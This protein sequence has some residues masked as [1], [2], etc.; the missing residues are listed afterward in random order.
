MKLGFEESQSAYSSGSQSARAWTE[1][2]VRSWAY[3]PN[4]GNTSL[5]SFPNNAPVADF[6]CG[7]C[8]EEFELKSKKGKFGP[9]LANGSFKTKC[10]RLAASN[11][12]NFFLIHR[13]C[14]ARQLSHST[15]GSRGMALFLNHYTCERCRRRWADEWSCMCDDSCP[16]C[17][18]RDIAPHT[19]EDLTTLIG[20]R[21]DAF[22]VL[23]SPET[24]EHE[25]DY[26]ELG[27]FATEQQ[28]I[29]FL[30]KD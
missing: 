20:R 2:W 12:P 11:N 15:I 10:E 7:S 5:N 21:K 9:K 23:W 1:S 18:A 25:P 13:I 17:G 6:F 24:A 28:A 8:H 29:D 14:R 30:S 19:S 27:C 4:C 16:R 3:C 22:V 26:R